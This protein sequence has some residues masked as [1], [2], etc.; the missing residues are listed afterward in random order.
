MREMKVAVER[1]IVTRNVFS[2]IVF[3]S[4][5]RKN[6]NKGVEDDICDVDGLLLNYQ[7]KFVNKNI[8]RY[9]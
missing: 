2:G 4:N 6:L 8:Y 3:V 7:N 5:E 1:I 9:I